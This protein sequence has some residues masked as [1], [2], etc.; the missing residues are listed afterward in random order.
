D[1]LLLPLRSAA[2]LPAP[3][4]SGAVAAAA[5]ADVLDDRPTLTLDAARNLLQE[6]DVSFKLFDDRVEM[7]GL[8]PL[9]TIE[10]PDGNAMEQSWYRSLHGVPLALPFALAIRR[11]A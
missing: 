8:L 1:V 9:P 2:A 6:Y 7:Q 10:L 3:T 5:L 4:V 11:A